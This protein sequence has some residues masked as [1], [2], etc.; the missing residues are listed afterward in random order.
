MNIGTRGLFAAED[1]LCC[2]EA[3]DIGIL[4]GAD[5]VVTD[6]IEARALLA[7]QQC[8]SVEVE[9]GVPVV[10]FNHLPCIEGPPEVGLL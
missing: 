8:I 2:I 9:R 1:S 4:E 10:A 3:G 6:E 5:V 7:L